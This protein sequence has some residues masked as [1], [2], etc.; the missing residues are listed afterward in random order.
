MLRIPFPMARLL[1]VG[2][3]WLSASLGLAGFAFLLTLL[4]APRWLA[5]GTAVCVALAGFCEFQWSRL[6]SLA[7]HPFRVLAASHA[8]VFGAGSHR[9]DGALIAAATV[10]GR[11]E[12]EQLHGGQ[13]SIRL[14]KFVAEPSGLDAPAL[15]RDWCYAC[16][17]GV[18]TQRENPAVPQAFVSPSR[19]LQLDVPLPDPSA[20]AGTR[21]TIAEEFSFE[22]D[23]ESPARFVFQPSYPAATQIVAIVFDGPRP[24]NARYRIERGLGNAESDELKTENGSRLGF[25]WNRAAA[26]DQLIIDWDWDPASLPRPMSETER[27]IAAARVRQEEMQKRL[28]MQFGEL[29]PDD[30][31]TAPA[32][33]LL[34]IRAARQRE[35]LYTGGDP[36]APSL[37]GDSGFADDADQTP[38]E[39]HPIIKAARAREKLYKTD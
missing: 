37:P 1:V 14:Q 36:G 21:F 23:L 20:P 7:R 17:I 32:E 16:G 19:S 4:E 28:A 33:E 6:R 22:A 25:V 12:F 29:A 2:G 3:A 15:L 24:V 13:S 9:A 18:A 5:L 27:L 11:T 34:L 8:V 39:E 26:G 30:A 31:D 38:A 10:R 35:T